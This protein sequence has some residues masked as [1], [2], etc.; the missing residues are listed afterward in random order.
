M[1]L[2]ERRH[3]YSLY[4][5][6][7]WRRAFRHLAARRFGVRYDGQ[8]P[9]RLIVAPTDLRSVDPFVAEEILEGRFPMAGRE[10]DTNGESPFYLELPSR[11]FAIRLHSFSWL[12]HIRAD[13]TDMACANARLIV[14]QWISA[15]GRRIA[16]IAWDPDVVAQR[17]IA[18]LSHSPVVL[19]GAEGGFYRR[20]MR[21]LFSQV[22]YLRR[23]AANSAD[24]EVRFRV[25]IALAMASVAMPSKTSAIRRAGRELDHEIERQILPDGGHISRN[26]RVAVDLLFDL[27]PLRQTYVNLGHDIPA[28]LIS[29]IDRIYPA[30]RFFRHQGGDLA[31]F[32]GATSTLAHELMSVLRYDESAGQPFK[33]LPHVGYQRLSAKDVVVIAD[34]GMPLSPDLSKTAHAGCLSFEFSSGKHRFVIN[35]GSPKFASDSYRQTARV[36][37]AHSTVV[38]N[39]TSSSRISPSP[40]LGPIMARGVSKVTAERSL[41]SDGSDCLVASH[42]GYLAAFG[43]V[44]QR[45]WRLSADGTRLSGRDCF[46]RADGTFPEESDTGEAVVRFHIH[47]LIDIVPT[48]VENVLLRAPDGES[49]VFSA[50][51]HV[52]D[53]T[54]DIFFADA[55]GIRA[56]EQLEIA[57]SVGRTPEIHWELRR[58][59]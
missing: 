27:L 2:S 29:G 48:D 52:V 20:F 42:D 40:F 12:R 15:H 1:H 17:I 23:V 5:R 4:V 53:I 33:A 38:L 55:S 47:P 19:Q 11:F 7:A 6:E 46:V 35:S 8:P 39:E 36:T 21:S 37:A 31:L 24:G 41:L 25:R 22:R 45:E 49:W 59:R 30:L 51:G 54:S 32:N 56:S 26:P 9:E 13:K 28:K 14:D 43:L 44:H 16:G 10:L 50:P 58:H 34:T 57:F 18:W 3:L